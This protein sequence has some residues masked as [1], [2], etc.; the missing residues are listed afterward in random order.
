MIYELKSIYII[1][2]T[3][4]SY[5]YRKRLKACYIL[6][7]VIKGIAYRNLKKKKKQSAITNYLK[8]KKLTLEQFYNTEDIKK[9]LA[10]AIE[11]RNNSYYK[12]LDQNRW[13]SNLETIVKDLDYLHNIV[14]NKMPS[15]LKVPKRRY[16]NL[17]SY[18]ILELLYNKYSIMS[19]TSYFKSFLCIGSCNKVINENIIYILQPFINNYSKMS[20]LNLDNEKNLFKFYVSWFG[21]CKNYKHTKYLH[22]VCPAITLFNLS[23]NKNLDNDLR[24]QIYWHIKKYSRELLKN[25]G[26]VL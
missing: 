9:N 13:I 1:Q 20:R 8:K 19:K 5:N 23:R 17:F 22:H 10:N 24:M 18:N 7:S 12:D 14:E 4:K 16:K 15:I 25:H 26:I 21:G 3:I 11:Y 6:N 2:A